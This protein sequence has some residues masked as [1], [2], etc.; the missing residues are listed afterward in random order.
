MPDVPTRRDHAEA[1][2]LFRAQIIGELT[3][4]D[5]DRGELATGFRALAI[6]RYRPPDS[7]TSRRFGASTL[8]RRF[9]ARTARGRACELTVAQRDLVDARF[10]R[11]YGK[12]TVRPSLYSISIVEMRAKS[13]STCGSSLRKTL[14]LQRVTFATSPPP[15]QL[16]M[17]PSTSRP[18]LKV[19]W[20]F[21]I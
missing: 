20:T 11:L 6:E 18:S 7:A 9:Y 5:L 10:Q 8:Q 15:P 21:F 12:T 16:L 13:K 17:K 4:R 3:R 14:C 1:V 19:T 2:A